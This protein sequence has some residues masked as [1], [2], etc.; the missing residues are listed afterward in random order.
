V[1]V[2]AEY[3][4]TQLD[5]KYTQSEEERAQRARAKME[6]LRAK[7]EETQAELRAL[8]DECK[9]HTELRRTMRL[10]PPPSI[11]TLSEL[12]NEFAQLSIAPSAFASAM[13]VASS[14]SAATGADSS[15]RTTRSSNRT[16]RNSNRPARNSSRAA[17][18][19]TSATSAASSG[20]GGRVP[21]PRR[22]PPNAG[23]TGG[24]AAAGQGNG[25][26]HEEGSAMKKAKK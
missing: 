22:F 25:L 1:A 12:F 11:D 26:T 21:I 15:N 4:A 10:G 13:V 7:M 20:A 19:S 9:E 16:A 24:A 6:E 5:D 18:A 17:T 8:A 14:A 3:Y 23:N 2:Q